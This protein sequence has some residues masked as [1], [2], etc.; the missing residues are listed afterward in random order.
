MTLYV[1]SVNLDNKQKSS[2]IGVK[3]IH[4]NLQHKFL[5]TYRKITIWW[6]SSIHIDSGQY[7]KKIYGSK[8]TLYVYS[9]NLDNKQKSSIIGVKNIHTNLQ[10]KFLKTYRKITIW[11]QSSIH[12]DSG[13]Y[14]KKIYKLYLLSS[15]KT[16]CTL[17]IRR[18]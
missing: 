1:Y 14:Y 10:H 6:Q 16:W 7:Y 12:I 3:N 8:V 9:V 17:F 11:W 2:I 4:T 18:Y 13:Q 5:K 15:H